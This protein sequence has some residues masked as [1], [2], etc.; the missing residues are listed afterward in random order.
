MGRKFPALLLLTAAIACAEPVQVGVLSLFRPE[1]LTLK[2]A[3]GSLLV[4]RA[5]ERTATVRGA[6]GLRAVG[7]EVDLFANSAMTSAPII[8]A[9]SPEGGPV[10]FL[11]AV[12]GKIERRYRGTLE[13][14]AAAGALEAVVTIDLETAV[15]AAVAAEMENVEAPAALEA[16]A[17]LAR[18]FYAASP[19]RHS[20][21]A[22]CDTTHCQFHR[23]PVRETHPAS[24]AATRTAGIVTT[25]QG[26]TF[27]PMYSASCGGRTRTAESVGMSPDPYP[28]FSVECE[29]CRRDAPAWERRVP[30]AIGKALLTA[31]TEAARI[32]IVRKLGWQA[33]P[34]NHFT[35]RDEGEFIVLSGRGEGHGVGLCQRGAARLA[36]QGSAFQQ[37]I[38]RYLP[39]VALKQ[40]QR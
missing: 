29:P 37:I 24:L 6:A 13:V 14:R 38:D 15:A 11:L 35:A 20:G 34:G 30:A 22:F 10:D 7:S 1:R 12:P 9:S 19:P 4:V 28:Y 17:V 27:P 33:V 5:G 25:Y 21:Y 23:S 16:M 26:K 3:N 18:S 39:N 40:L 8:R 36:V 32:Q 2:P 31:P